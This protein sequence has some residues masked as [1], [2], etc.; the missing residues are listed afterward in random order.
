MKKIKKSDI[1][2]KGCFF[3]PKPLKN[4]T[5]KCIIKMNCVK[6]YKKLQNV[7]KK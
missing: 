7:I 1:H 6:Y 4:K 2:I 3:Y 5:K